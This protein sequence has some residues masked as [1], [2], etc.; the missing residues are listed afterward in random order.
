[1]L[2]DG[3]IAAE[4]YMKI[5]EQINDPSRYLYLTDDIKARIQ[6]T[7][8]PARIIYNIIAFVFLMTQF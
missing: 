6:S 2:I 4:P 3:L 8:N 1:M 5:A 7:V